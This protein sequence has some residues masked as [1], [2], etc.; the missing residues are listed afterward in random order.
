MPR[1]ASVPSIQAP[2]VDREQRHRRLLLLGLTAL[3]VLSVSPIFG[4]HVLGASAWLP[5]S[6]EHLGPF[7]MVALHHLLAPVHGGFHLLLQAGVLFALIERTRAVWRH[8]R[9][10]RSLSVMACGTDARLA[11][12]AHAVGC[13]PDRVHLV[14]GLLSPAF[15]SG[16]F[17]PHIYVSRALPS[18]L[19]RD[20]LEAVLAHEQAHA[21]RRDPLRQFAWRTLAGVLFWL[22][23]IRRLAEELADEAEI[24]A[25]D[26][27]A[28][29]RALP[30]ASAI[31]R[32]AGADVGPV[33]LSVGF[34]RRDLLERRVRRLAGEDAVV[35]FQVSRRTL[36][37]AALI[38]VAVW[39]SGVIVLHPLPA[40]GHATQH[41]THT[42]AWQLSHLFCNHSR[43]SK[44]P[45][46]H[47][48]PHRSGEA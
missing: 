4:H 32:M 6:L 48:T 28:R 33:G 41:C 35:G 27:A 18:Q 21:R 44:A 30:L 16:W 5:A 22:P 25:D 9:T 12:A 39:T 37:S 11:A 42:G 36:V 23:A 46:E 1:S 45:C 10:M 3:L 14:D 7:C 34:Q 2:L 29:E 13:A 38:L 31:L 19:C 15:T 17:T 43:A 40:A 24:R 8:T 20:E 47:S 26:V